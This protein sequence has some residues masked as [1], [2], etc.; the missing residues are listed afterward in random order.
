VS[1]VRYELGSCIPE[2]G[3]LRSHCR[4]NLKSY[5]RYPPPPQNPLSLVTS[6]NVLQFL[7]AASAVSHSDC[8]HRNFL[9]PDT[10][11]IFCSVASTQLY[12]RRLLASTIKNIQPCI[13]I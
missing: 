4:G 13:S 9:F 10:D 2:D 5:D 11:A 3:T 1:P 8:I 6:G 7:V 12:N